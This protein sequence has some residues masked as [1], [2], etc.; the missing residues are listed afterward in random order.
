MEQPEI[1]CNKSDRLGRARK[2][3]IDLEQPKS[4]SK[5]VEQSKVSSFIGGQQ[6]W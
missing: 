1:G 6:H 3:K 4:N 2:T 5:Q